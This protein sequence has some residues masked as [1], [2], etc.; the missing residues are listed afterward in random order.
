MDTST[1]LHQIR[2][3][4]KAMTWVLLLPTTSNLDH[5]IVQKVLVLLNVNTSICEPIIMCLLYGT[6][7]YL[8]EDMQ[9][10]EKIQRRAIK[11]IL[12][13]KQFSYD[14]RCLA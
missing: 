4:N 3:I 5:K 10:I 7:S 1:E 11:L 2:K 9:T 8:L 13:L 6:L 14:E 12:S